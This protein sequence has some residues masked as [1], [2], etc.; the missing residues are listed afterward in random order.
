M[1]MIALAWGLLAV[2]AQDPADPVPPA[3]RYLAA[4]QGDNGSWGKPPKGCRCPDPQPGEGDLEATAWALLA[5]G[6]SGFTE[7]SKNDVWSGRVVAKVVSSGLDWLISR[8]D[9][10]G[11]F[12]RGDASLNALPALALLEAHGL[13]GARKASAEKALAWVEQSRCSDVIGRIRQGMVLK[14]AEHA[15]LRGKP[16][17]ELLRLSK[18]LDAAEGEL[19]KLGSVLLQQY[20]GT[21]KHPRIA[22][23]PAAAL[24]LPLESLNLLTVVTYRQDDG[25]EWHRWFEALRKDCRARQHQ[26]VAGCELGSWEARSFR[27]RVLASSLAA[28]CFEHF[29]CGYCKGVFRKRD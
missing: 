26:Q 17:V 5:F 1:S 27:E 16:S 19:A 24:K 22:L 20:A 23:D 8:Q 7:L 9:A 12:D 10:D 15:E 13:G 2:L 6:G 11:A 3:L 4:H 21:L 14:S 25:A 28:Y 18:A 29:G